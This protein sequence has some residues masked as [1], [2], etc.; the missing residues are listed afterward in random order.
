MTLTVER[1]N[2]L[3]CCAW[4]GAAFLLGTLLWVFT[5]SLRP[6]LLQRAANRVIARSGETRRL[7][8]P[9]GQTGFG[10][11]YTLVTVPDN[12]ST[13]GWAL[14]FTLMDGTRAAVC[15]A[16]V[17]HQGNIEK[18]IPLSEYAVEVTADLPEPVYNLYKERIRAALRTGPVRSGGVK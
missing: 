13:E 15:A 5:R 12:T 18:L 11:W 14:V 7:D 1:R 3:L 6:Q 16:F 2:L 10:T 17:D 9:A 4:I 8:A